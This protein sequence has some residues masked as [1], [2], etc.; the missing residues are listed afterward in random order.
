MFE[1]LPALNANIIR[2]GSPTFFAAPF[3]PDLSEYEADV[4]FLGVPF[5]HGINDRPGSRFGPLAV[6]DASMRLAPVG[7]DG[8]YDI[9]E[10][11]RLLKGV[12]MA[13]AGD[14]N[15]SNV[16][17]MIN[18]D[19]IT[20]AV[21]IIRRS[22]AF[23][24]IIGGDHSITFP[25]IRAFSDL[26]LTVVHFDAHMDFTD[27]WKGQRYSHDNQMRRVI[28]LPFVKRLC[29]LGIRTMFDRMEPLEAAKAYGVTVV[30]ALEM[31]K[32]GPAEVI[33][34]LELQGPCYVTIDIDVMDP[35]AVPGTGYPEPG[36]LFYYQ[37]K[38][39]I[40]RLGT[41]SNVVGF[42]LVE[43]SPPHDI[44]S[45]VTARTAARLLLDTLGAI[46]YRQE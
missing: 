5:D 10:D 18:F 31:I 40:V 30:S 38:E 42:D 43:V 3:V 4:A 46:F 8:W 17:R 45:G 23:P 6:R 35:A 9:E 12:R 34:S 41:K 21:S 25:I 37:L 1:K 36:G 19:K 27:E 39:A 14:V 13:D 28:E 22:G 29:Q 2:S 26:P 20:E 24:A 16:D 44:L 33:D 15:I 32:R 7:L 11:K